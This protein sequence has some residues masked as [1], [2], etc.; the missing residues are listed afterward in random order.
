MGNKQNTR[1]K[2]N[3][4]NY[5]YSNNYNNNDNLLNEKD[6]LIKKV[7]NLNNLNVSKSEI[8]E[9]RYFYENN[10]EIL[11]KINKTIN[12]VKFTNCYDLTPQELLSRID[13][14]HTIPL[15]PGVP[16]PPNVPLPPGVP[17][18]PGII[19][20]EFE[21]PKY[22]L[23]TKWEDLFK[24]ECDNTIITRLYIKSEIDRVKKLYE[25]SGID[26]PKLY[27]TNYEYYESLLLD[28][29]KQK[30]N[31]KLE[32]NEEKNKIIKEDNYKSNDEVIKEIKELKYFI[33]KEKE[34]KKNIDYY[35]ENLGLFQKI[36]TIISNAKKCNLSPD[37]G[38]KEFGYT[39]DLNLPEKWEDLFKLEWPEWKIDSL[40]DFSN[41]FENIKNKTIKNND[42]RK[43][44]VDNIKQLKNL[45]FDINQV[46]KKL[47]YYIEIFPLL[48]KNDTIIEYAKK[49]CFY[50]SSTPYET[51]KNVFGYGHFDNKTWEELYLKKE[52]EYH[53]FHLDQ[54][55]LSSE[56][57]MLRNLF[58]RKF[59]NSKALQY[60]SRIITKDNYQEYKKDY[61]VVEKKDKILE[62][63][64]KMLKYI[65]GKSFYLDDYDKG[66]IEEFKK[67]NL[68]L[69]SELETLEQ[70]ENKFKRIKKSIIN[71]IERRKNEEND[72]DDNDDSN[73]NN[74]S[75]YSSSNNYNNSNKGNDKKKVYLKL[76]QNCKNKCVGCKSSISG[77]KGASKGF[78]IHSKC[79]TSSCYI[80]G[81]SN[82]TVHER[83]TSY[84]CKSCYSSNK[85]DVSK[86]FDCHKSF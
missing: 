72:D 54:L 69:K 82:S 15:P 47:D 30:G 13:E 46:K 4:N 84:L 10:F 37:V 66:I 56:V 74:Y 43:N 49:G 52:G 41:N 29:G 16:P 45:K 83:N 18:P 48:K 75:S 80:C 53:E 36:N 19:E 44:I 2:Y 77:G 12:N 3:D 35:R 24:L 51:Y 32:K 62:N 17:P 22:S 81:K 73:N 67:L 14:E 58:N 42:K 79:Q 57:C 59:D 27:I 86:C 7:K 38:F 34:I 70:Y 25:D 60:W 85:F 68:T 76:C 8:E 64:N 6:P 26:C 65:E 40:L 33:I 1:G 63:I 71:E 11:Y 55:L 31:N 39:S 23:P 5:S 20:N 9:N 28:K 61:E 50:K 78:G 21:E